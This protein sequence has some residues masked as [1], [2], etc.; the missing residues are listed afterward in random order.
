MSLRWAYE[1]C[2]ISNFTGKYHKTIKTRNGEWGRELEG[3]CPYSLK[4]STNECGLLHLS[5]I[6]VRCYE[7]SKTAT[8]EEKEPKDQIEHKFQTQLNA[9]YCF[10]HS[11]SVE[12]WKVNPQKYIYFLQIKHVIYS[13][14]PFFWPC[15]KSWNFCFAFPDFQPP[16]W[17]QDQIVSPER[18][19][20]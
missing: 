8:A 5:E 20:H 15:I 18:H 12:E 19:W 16:R 13:S 1:K 6:H 14:L 3:W 7:T 17:I 9:V 2:N 10:Q 11:E 4:I